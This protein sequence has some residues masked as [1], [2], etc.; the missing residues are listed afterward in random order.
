M[1]SSFLLGCLLLLCHQQ[2]NLYTSAQSDGNI[3]PWSDNF[4]TTNG[5]GSYTINTATAARQDTSPEVSKKILIDLYQATGGND[6]SDDTNFGSSQDIC[7]WIGVFCYDES[8]YPS[9]KGQVQ[10]IDLSHNN[11]HGSLPSNFYSLPYLESV[12]FEGNPDLV[13]DLSQGLYSAQHLRVLNLS[14]TQATNLDSLRSAPSLEVLYIRDMGLEGAIP[15]SLFYLTDLK[16]LH[17]SENKFSGPLPESIGSLT[18]LEEL[19]LNNNDL[20]GQLPDSLG[21]LSLL[22]ILTDRKSVV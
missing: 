15:D 2:H 21:Q 10:Q 4:G 17:A 3:N 16:V 1:S 9:R 8:A 20:T 14:K 12:N 5:G 6:W 19:T 11:L 7:T 22:Q 18:S 13:V